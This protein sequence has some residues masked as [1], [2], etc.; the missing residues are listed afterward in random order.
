MTRI[1]RLRISLKD[2]KPAP[3]R[4]IE[5]PLRITLDQLHDAIQ[6][7]MGWEDMHLHEFRVGQSRWS[8]L[9]RTGSTTART[10]PTRL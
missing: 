7:A 4:Q 8:G 1:A 10:P 3:M 9:I 6:A 5:V 2:I